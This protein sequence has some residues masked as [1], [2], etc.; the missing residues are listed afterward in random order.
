[1]RTVVLQRQ[2]TPISLEMLEYLHRRSQ[3]GRKRLQ[4]WQESLEYAGESVEGCR[5]L[6]SLASVR[7]WTEQASRYDMEANGHHFFGLS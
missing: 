1:M 5:R 7:Y 3:K 4:R 6:L 2:V